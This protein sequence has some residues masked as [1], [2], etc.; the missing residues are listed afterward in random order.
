MS[1]CRVV[2]RGLRR[3]GLECLSL[4]LGAGWEWGSELSLKGLL[5]AHL[6][7]HFILFALGQLEQKPLH[8]LCPLHRAPFPNNL[9]AQL[10]L[11]S[12]LC[13]L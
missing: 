2:P 5:C 4:H 11:H 1:G 8:T 10:S 12:D 13:F 7:G 3:G 6:S 9:L